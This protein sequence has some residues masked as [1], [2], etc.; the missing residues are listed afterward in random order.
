GLLN[1]SEFIPIAE[2]TGLIRE[3]GWWSLSEA[4]RQIAKWRRLSSSAD[5][6]SSV[7]LSVKQFLQPTFAGQLDELL[8]ELKLPE[9]TLK[10]EL[11]ESSIM[12]DPVAAVSLL[13]QIKAL[14]IRLAI[15][16]FGPGYSSR[17]EE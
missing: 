4:C 11:T 13:A 16:D 10:L 17:S 5:L 12:T 1:P 3:V 8:H 6:T 14:G 9:G 15:D 7:N 2:E